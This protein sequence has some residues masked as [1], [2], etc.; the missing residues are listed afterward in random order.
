MFFQAWSVDGTGARLKRA[1]FYL[2]VALSAAVGALWM[3][4]FYHPGGRVISG[5][6][7][8]WNMDNNRGRLSLTVFS[9]IPEDEAYWTLAIPYWVAESVAMPA[10][11]FM[12]WWILRENHSRRARGFPL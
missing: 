12:G 5:S 6:H 2:L 8:T 9:A 1:F 7:Y 10:T 11:F 3:L 4:S